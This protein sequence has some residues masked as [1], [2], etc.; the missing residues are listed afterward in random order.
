MI[1]TC[2]QE[3]SPVVVIDPDFRVTRFIFFEEF[4]LAGRNGPHTAFPGK[5]I[6]QRFCRID[7][8][9]CPAFEFCI[10]FA[11]V[12]HLKCLDDHI[13]GLHIAD[14]DIG[15]Y[16]QLRSSRRGPPGSGSSGQFQNGTPADQIV[17]VDGKS[18]SVCIGSGIVDRDL[19]DQLA[20][21]SVIFLFQRHE[22]A[23]VGD[24][25]VGHFI[26]QRGYDAVVGRNAD[27]VVFSPGVRP[28]EMTA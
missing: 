18:R 11:V 23:V 6:A 12:R 25:F 3:N 8:F 28:L 19:F 4:L 16:F 27:G 7:G 1:D 17:P 10:G 24:P 21:E 14:V 20:A 22:P 15:G 26:F 9:V 13:P 5:H 2:S